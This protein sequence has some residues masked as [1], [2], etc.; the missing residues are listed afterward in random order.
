MYVCLYVLIYVCTNIYLR[1][2]SPCMKMQRP[3]CRRFTYIRIHRYI[4]YARHVWKWKGHNAAVLF[5]FVSANRLL[6][7]VALATYFI[8]QGQSCNGT[9]FRI[10]MCVNKCTYICVYIHVQIYTAVIYI[11]WYTHTHTLLIHA[12]SIFLPAVE[13]LGLRFSVFLPAVAPTPYATNIDRTLLRNVQRKN[14]T[15]LS[16]TNRFPKPSSKTLK[17]KNVTMLSSTNRFPK[18]SR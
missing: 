4:V 10:C 5:F 6:A 9:C 14:A 1:A 12:F 3:S 15:K 17:C 7:A 2:C 8:C 16:S 11:Y 13:G 18:P